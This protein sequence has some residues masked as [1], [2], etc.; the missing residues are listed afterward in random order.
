MNNNMLLLI[1]LCFILSVIAIVIATTKTGKRGSSGA[2]G[3][4]GKS[5]TCGNRGKDGRDGRDGKDGTGGLTQGT[6][7]LTQGTSGLTQGTSGL[8]QGTSGL[9]QGTSGLTQGTITQ[10]VFL[11]DIQPVMK[12]NSIFTATNEWIDAECKTLYGERATGWP[13]DPNDSEKIDYILNDNCDPDSAETTHRQYYCN[14]PGYHADSTFD[15]TTYDN[16]LTYKDGKV[17]DANSDPPPG[18]KQ[19]R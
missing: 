14:I 8:T 15:P 18:F 11:G 13:R 1:V 7:G 3:D 10:E 6:G 12:C 2:R 4:E 16:G 9:T 5:G 19:I 17:V